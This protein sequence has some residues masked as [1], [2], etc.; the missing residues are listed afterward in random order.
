MCLKTTVKQQYYLS[1][2]LF[3]E[4]RLYLLHSREENFEIVLIFLDLQPLNVLF[5]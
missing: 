1:W 2:L 4:G 5:C 3:I